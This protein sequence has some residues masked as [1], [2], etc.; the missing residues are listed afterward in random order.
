VTVRL[1]SLHTFSLPLARELVIGGRS[2][3][4]R[5][6][7]FI[8]LQSEDGAIGIGEIAPLPGFHKEDLKQCVDLLLQHREIPDDLPEAC[9][10]LPSVHFGLSMARINLEAASLGLRPAAVLTAE[11]LTE[12]CV[13]G[14]VMAPH[15]RWTEEVRSLVNTGYTVIK[16]KVGR[17][18]VASE[19]QAL[20][21]L[22]EQYGEGIGYVLDG[23]RAWSM[24]EALGFFEQVLPGHI[25]Y[26]EEL[27]RDPRNLG[28]LA[29]RVRIPMALDETLYDANANTTLIR[30]WR[31]VFVLKPDR[32]RGGIERCLELSSIAHARRQSVIVSS[33]FHSPVGLSFLAQLG[34]AMHCPHAGL[35]T[36]RWFGDAMPESSFSIL[37]GIIQVEDNWINDLSALQPF[38]ETV[39]ES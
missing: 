28:A 30:D 29:Q 5:A 24:D 10:A 20:R 12:L 32:I 35:D 33:A 16:I 6:G 8:T 7:V 21:T 1:Q 18:E 34:A 39:W 27:L 36:Y 26:G 31:G 4:E 19:A 13:N 9:R 2:M 25:C 3:H 23:N 14:L 11:P 17:G 22:Q 37:N 38:I 15:D